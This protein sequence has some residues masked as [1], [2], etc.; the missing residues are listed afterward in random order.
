MLSKVLSQYATI[1]ENESMKHHTTFGIGGTVSMLVVPNTVTDI[2]TIL[3]ICSEAEKRVVILGNGSNVLFSDDPSDM[4][5]LKNHCKE[6]SFGECMVSVSSGYMLTACAFEAA[7][8]SL[9]GL[10]FAYGIP[11]SVGGG[12]YMNAGAYG[13]ELSQVITKTTYCDYNGNIYAICGDAHQFGYRHSVFKEMKNICILHTEMQLTHGDEQ[14]I[15]QTMD[16][17]M[18][19]RRDKQPLEYPNAGSVFKRPAGMFAGKLIE[20]CGLK[21]YR[22]G[23]AQVSEKHA[24]FIV[25][26]GEATANDVKTLIDHIQKTVFARFGVE[27]ECE[28]EMI[29]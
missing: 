6:I 10:E 28:I 15:R 11:G 13:G 8:R 17:L 23:G 5:V 26:R 25:N 24:G 19:R 20:D 4:I 22:I 14:E 29:G 12:V 16:D 9:A 3:R 2:P 18:Q 27:L 1:R 21:G 7:K